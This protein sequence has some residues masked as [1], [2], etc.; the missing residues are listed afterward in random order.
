M[1]NSATQRMLLCRFRGIFNSF[2]DP[3]Y[4]VYHRTLPFPPKTTVCGMFGA[5]LGLSPE[6][7]NSQL[8][9]GDPPGL[10]VAIIVDQVNGKAKDLWKIKK[11]AIGEKKTEDVVRIGD[12][13]Y[14]GAVIVRE[15]HFASQF[16]I[17]VRSE[18]ASLLERLYC[19]LR[20]PIWALSLGRDD[21]LVRVLDLEWSDVKKLEEDLSYERVVLPAGK[22]ALDMETLHTT[23]GKAKK[24][25]PPLVT[26]L[27]TRFFYETNGEREGRDWQ[28]FL[29]ASG[30][31]IK[32]VNSRSKAY[33]DGENHFQFF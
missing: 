1:T 20:N 14:Y 7:V 22:Y 31:A 8:L 12:K 28:P 25:Q 4:T 9:E 16:T 11:V 29:F 27:P 24:L 2:R 3:T 10:E 17:Y 15:M 6:E 33:T 5:A 30:I 19:A 13:Y 23:N 32:P 18:D 26:K 21:E